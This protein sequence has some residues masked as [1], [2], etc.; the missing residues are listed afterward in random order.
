MAES[1]LGGIEEECEKR[2]IEYRVIRR[3]EATVIS[4][5]QKGIKFYFSDRSIEFFY[6]DD[7]KIDPKGVV[8]KIYNQF[9]YAIRSQSTDPTRGG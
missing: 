2:H 8:E 5:Y 4:S 1:F 9:M 7:G 3:K 6:T